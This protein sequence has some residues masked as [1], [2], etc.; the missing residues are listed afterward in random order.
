MS[1][2]TCMY[3]CIYIYIYIYM[4]IFSLDKC[5]IAAAPRLILSFFLI[6]CLGGQAN[7]KLDSQ[8]NFFFFSILNIRELSH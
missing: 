7:F 1:G 8:C 6:F 3:V 2:Y 4:H 5:Y